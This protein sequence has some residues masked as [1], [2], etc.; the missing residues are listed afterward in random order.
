MV[1]VNRGALLAVI[2]LAGCDPGTEEARPAPTTAASSPTSS[3]VAA[4]P[5]DCRL[6]PPEPD[7]EQTM[8]VRFYVLCGDDPGG[9]NQSQLL[10]L[11]RRVPRS[12][13]VLRAAIEE[14]LKGITEEERRRGFSS[15]L[16]PAEGEAL[17]ADV[18]VSEAGTATIDFTERFVRLGNISASHASMVVFLTLGA[19]VGQFPTVSDVVYRVEGDVDDKNFC[20][21][22][23]SDA[24]CSKLY[25]PLR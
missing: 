21:F 7:D 24:G 1:F 16:F 15:F 22:F 20:G 9:P 12:P 14:Y 23:E 8:T 25:R 6:P 5:S 17:L 11:P 18:S 4:T 10:A 3:T 13:M 19:T 2:I